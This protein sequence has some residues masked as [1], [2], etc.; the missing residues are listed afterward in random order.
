MLIVI[1]Q[2]HPVGHSGEAGKRPALFARGHGQ[3]DLRAMRHGRAQQLEE[4]QIA[5]HG[6]ARQRFQVH[7]QPRLMV[8]GN[9]A[10]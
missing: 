7:D 2:D 5:G 9:K 8:A 1:H 10:A 6:I 4:A 3:R